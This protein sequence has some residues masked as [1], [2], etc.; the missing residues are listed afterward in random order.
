MP[1]LIDLLMHPE[2]GSVVLHMYAFGMV[3]D[4]EKGEAQAKKGI[5]VM[6]SSGE[7]FKRVDCRCSNEASHPEL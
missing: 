3:A 1:E 4:D 2:I 5:R 7:V 6:S